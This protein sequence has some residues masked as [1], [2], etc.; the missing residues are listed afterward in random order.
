MPRTTLALSLACFTL[1]TG[2]QSSGVHPVHT[3]PA[4]TVE[5]MDVLSK[6]EGEWEMVSADGTTGPGSV[7]HVTAGGSA[8]R[9]IMFPGHEHEMTNLYHMDGTEVVCTH[10][11]A[12]GN[13]PRMVASGITQTDEGPALDFEFDSVSNF[14]EG[15]DHYMGGLRV[16]FVNDN[17]IHQDWTSFDADGNVANTITF[18][19]KR[20][21]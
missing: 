7:F 14:I 16:T 6:L 12:A 13:Q 10:Y 20:K 8:V 9:E 17:T 2:C 1:L 19:L 4:V 3:D 15:Q 21:G 11:C 18:V 5:S